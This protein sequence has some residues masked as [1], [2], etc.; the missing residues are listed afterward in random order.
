MYIYNMYINGMG[1]VWCLAPLRHK[2]EG[3]PC[4]PELD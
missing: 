1:M 4:E 2:Q 3:S